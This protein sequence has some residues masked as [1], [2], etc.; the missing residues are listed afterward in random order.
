LSQNV[1]FPASATPVYHRLFPTY[2]DSQAAVLED[3]DSVA[4]P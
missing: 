1:F 2:T 4:F 3:I